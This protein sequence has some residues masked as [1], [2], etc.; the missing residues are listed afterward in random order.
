MIEDVF[1]P[2][3]KNEIIEKL[4]EA[5]VSVEGENMRGVTW[6]TIEEVKSGDWGIGGKVL[7]IGFSV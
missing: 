3:Q 4:T 2:Q 6:V 7:T 5:M 1:S